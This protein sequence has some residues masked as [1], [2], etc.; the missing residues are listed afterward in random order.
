MHLSIIFNL[1]SA[2][3][4]IMSGD[5]SEMDVH[6][7]IIFNLLFARMMITSGDPSKM[8]LLTTSF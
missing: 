7:S 2:R 6:L 8:A 3:M 5:P 1:L 4:M